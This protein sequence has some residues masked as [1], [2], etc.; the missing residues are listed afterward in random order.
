M[1]SATASASG[2]IS[3]DTA[4]AVMGKLKQSNKYIQRLH[5]NTNDALA[6]IEEYLCQPGYE[7]GD[8]AF[9]T[10]LKVSYMAVLTAFE[11]SKVVGTCYAKTTDDNGKVTWVQQNIERA[12]SGNIAHW[13]VDVVRGGKKVR[14]H[15]SKCE[16]ERLTKI[17][18]EQ[19]G[20]KD[21][22]IHG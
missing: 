17:Y 13:D 22:V 21:V 9:S 3:Q 14:V 11:R 10:G 2:H 12:Y 5:K 7:D 4:I 6:A 15:L 8:D 1:N 18:E 20:L 19:P 16:V